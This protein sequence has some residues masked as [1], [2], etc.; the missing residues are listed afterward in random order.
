MSLIMLPG[1]PGFNETL[2]TPRPDWEE[3]AARDGNTYALVV[4]ED[5]IA[6]PVTSIELEEYLEGGEYEQRLMQLG[7][8]RTTHGL[9][10]DSSPVSS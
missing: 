2:L 9:E 3:V 6:R 4:G 7:E 10:F 5:G 1:D 8:L